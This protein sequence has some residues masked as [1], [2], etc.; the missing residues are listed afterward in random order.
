MEK[1]KILTICA[2]VIGVYACNGH[3]E[4]NNM[5]S[6]NRIEDTRKGDYANKEPDADRHVNS[7]SRPSDWRKE[8]DSHMDISDIYGSLNMSDSQIREYESASKTQGDNWQRKNKTNIDNQAILVRRDSSLQS[9]LTPEQYQKY[10]E[11]S[12]DKKTE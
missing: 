7:A 11:M 2:L 3:K 12:K 8:Y 10:K 4:K 5:D 9:V 1:L 6:S